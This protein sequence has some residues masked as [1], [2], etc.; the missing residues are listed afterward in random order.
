MSH[1]KHEIRSRIPSNIFCASPQNHFTSK[2]TKL[3]M[4]PGAPHVKGAQPLEKHL[5]QNV[6][7]L[8][9]NDSLVPEGT[10]LYAPPITEP[11][12]FLT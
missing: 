1:P 5:S 3:S 6:Q 2:Y 9:W 12:L 4:Q 10:Q 8:P 11:S 7:L